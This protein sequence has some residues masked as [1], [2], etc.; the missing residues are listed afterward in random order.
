[1]SNYF[2]PWRRKIGVVTLVMACVFAAVWARTTDEESVN[3]VEFPFY[4]DR[5]NLVSIPEGI[6][7]GKIVLVRE[8]G[9]EEFMFDD[10]FEIPHWAIVF[11]LTITSVLLLLSKPRM[12]KSK[13]PSES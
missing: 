5:Y 4:D 11:P 1:M 8:A 10:F 12:N 3:G 9:R 2:K 7:L 13:S 6:V